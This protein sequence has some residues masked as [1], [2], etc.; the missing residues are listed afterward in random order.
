[1]TPLT[2]AAKPRS[3][4]GDT[5][6]PVITLTGGFLFNLQPK[7]AHAELEPLNGPGLPRPGPH[8]RPLLYLAL[9]R[10]LSDRRRGRP[11]LLRLA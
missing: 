1:M 8:C 4:P 10:W 3:P 9:S 11:G 5:G 2:V 7:D 6:P